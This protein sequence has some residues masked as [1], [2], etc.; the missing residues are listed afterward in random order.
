[1]QLFERANN[2]GDQ[3]YAEVSVTVSGLQLLYSILRSYEIFGTVRPIQSYTN[4]SVRKGPVSGR[5]RGRRQVA[6]VITDL[7]CSRMLTLHKG[8]AATKRLLER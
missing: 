6:L 3:G 2:R 4:C 8:S 5:T 7:R 1:M